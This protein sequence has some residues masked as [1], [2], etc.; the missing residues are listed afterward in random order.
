MKN[1]CI[2]LRHS[3]SSLTKLALFCKDEHISTD[4]YATLLSFFFFTVSTVLFCVGAP[5]S[6]SKVVFVTT[7]KVNKVEGE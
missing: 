1:T 2:V 7:F 4:V 5:H 6:T 3:L